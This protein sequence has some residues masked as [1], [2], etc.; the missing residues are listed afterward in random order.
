MITISVCM[1]VK[2][3]EAVLERCLESLKPIADELIIVDTGSSDSTKEIASRYTDKIYDYE[4]QNDFAHARNYSFSK[5]TMEYIYTADADE[6]IDQE[7]R[8]RFIKLKQAMLYEVEIV[9]MKYTN[10][11]QFGTTYNYETE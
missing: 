8:E 6:W 10:Q 7:N 1:I 11:L 5:A 4:W 2:N 3:E 9:Q